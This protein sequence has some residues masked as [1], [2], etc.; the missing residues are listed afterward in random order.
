MA[1]A[2]SGT[3]RCTLCPAYLNDNTEVT[4]LRAQ[5]KASNCDSLYLTPCPVAACL[6]PTPGLCVPSDAGATGGECL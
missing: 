1:A 2:T 5:W 4:R 3:I 6:L